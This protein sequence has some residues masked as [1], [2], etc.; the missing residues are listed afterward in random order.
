MKRDYI[1]ADAS[2]KY[3]N[4]KNPL[5]ESLLYDGAGGWSRNLNIAFKYLP[6]LSP[7]FGESF[8][9]L[10]FPVNEDKSQ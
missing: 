6:P 7:F 3:M 1:I 10:I 2:S 9:W 4:A 5:E 8:F